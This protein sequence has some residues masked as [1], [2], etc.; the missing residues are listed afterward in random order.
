MH[1]LDL[2][3]GF[4]NLSESFTCPLCQEELMSGEKA[5]MARHLEEVSLTIVPANLESNEDS[6]GNTG[7]ESDTETGVSNSFL[8][9]PDTINEPKA[10]LVTDHDNLS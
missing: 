2:E 6:D 5:H 4:A 10:G 7:D 9:K 1:H 3:H 8:P